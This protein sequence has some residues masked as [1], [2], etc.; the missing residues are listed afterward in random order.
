LEGGGEEINDERKGP[1]QLKACCCESRTCVFVY[2]Q[3]HC[4]NNLRKSLHIAQQSKSKKIKINE[5]TG[6]KKSEQI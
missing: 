5:E 1:G 4:E 2:T 6:T 3:P